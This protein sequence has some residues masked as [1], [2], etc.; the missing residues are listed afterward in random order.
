MSG[1]IK[2]FAVALS[3]AFEISLAFVRIAKTPELP[4]GGAAACASFSEKALLG[5]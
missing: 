2:E 4:K 3:P 1:K 5:E